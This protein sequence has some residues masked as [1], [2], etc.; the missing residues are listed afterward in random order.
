MSKE[1]SPFVS[2]TFEEIMDHEAVTYVVQLGTDVWN[3]KGQWAFNKKSANMYYNKILRQIMH[4]LRTGN[5]KQIH[6][7]KIMLATLRILPLRI[8]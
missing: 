6:N 7:A 1:K 4:T 2:Y 5:E 8:H 3:V